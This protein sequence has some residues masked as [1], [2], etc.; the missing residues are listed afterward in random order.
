MLAYRLKRQVKHVAAAVC[1]GRPMV[2]PAPP[3]LTMRR[4]D[5]D[6]R[7]FL[8]VLWSTWAD[9]EPAD[10]DRE[11]HDW[12]AELYSDIAHFNRVLHNFCTDVWSYISIGFFV[13]FRWL[14]ATGLSCA[15]QR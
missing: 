10:A 12:R 1:L 3:L 4:F 7:M 8:T 15:A 6:W 9:L 13:R 5:A 14:G 11:S 2:Q